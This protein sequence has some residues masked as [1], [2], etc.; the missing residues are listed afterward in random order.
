MVDAPE[1]V[2]VTSPPL[3]AEVPALAPNVIRP[4]A[5]PP[6]PPPPPTL[7]AKIAGAR[8]P[9]VETPPLLVTLTAPPLMV[10][11]L[12]LAAPVPPNATTPSALPPLP[13]PPPML[14]ARMPGPPALT[15]PLF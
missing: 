7:C 8:L 12:P 6:L 14:C 4:L 13:P 11:P 2:T 9:V 15:V 1:A 10:L 3:P 5:L